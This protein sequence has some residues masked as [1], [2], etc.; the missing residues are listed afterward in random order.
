LDQSDTTRII[1][2]EALFMG[3]SQ[4]LL[5]GIDLGTTNIKALVAEMDGK[6]V[7]EASEPVT[8]TFSGD[9]GAE[10]DIEETWD[11]AVRAVSAAAAKVDA[12]RIGSI[13]VSSQGGAIQILESSGKPMGP[14]ISWQDSRGVPWDNAL[15]EKKGGNWFVRH[16]GFA[17]SGGAVGQLLRLREQ[18]ALPRGFVL[19]FV[20]DEVVGRLCGRRAHERT[21]LSEPGL[22]NP[23]TGEADEE[24]M[25]IL[26]LDPGRMPALLP[27]EEPAGGLRPEAADLLRLPAGIPVGPAVHDQYAAAI[28]SASVRAGDVML[29]AG[30]TWAILAITDRI[31]PPVAGIAM[32]GPHPVPG[33]YGQMLSMVNGGSSVSWAVRTLS[34]GRPG[35]A[36]LDRIMDSVPPGSAGV[37]VWPLFSGIGGGCLPR[38]TSA[39][40]DGLRQDHTAAHI[41]RAVVEGLACELGRYLSLMEGG[42]LSIQRLAM[43]GKAAA[44][45]VTPQVIADTTGRQVDCS[46]L[47]ETSSFGAVILARKLLEPRTGLAQLADAMKPAMRRVMPG[48]GAA[49]AA[50]RLA[51]YKASLPSENGAMPGR[52]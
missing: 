10:Q 6:I 32:V 27:V 14:V 13:G 25:G 29:G 35:I 30:T 12:A 38:G 5:L 17:R 22:L 36:E 34:L 3:R 33:L 52:A 44:S 43:C 7:S 51:Q 26:G 28:G 50:E 8:V 42:G 47:T 31:M 18:G 1:R 39:R 40:I 21:S 20:G 37:R 16:A 49:E 45:R 41:V 24:L 11:A 23:H 15:T 4:P 9:G 2:K 46:A 48:P 19:A